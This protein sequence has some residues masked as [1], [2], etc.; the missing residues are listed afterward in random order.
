MLFVFQISYNGLSLL[1]FCNVP[2]QEDHIPDE[3]TV[4]QGRRSFQSSTGQGISERTVG[5]GSFRIQEK[6]N[7]EE[8]DEG[9]LN[10]FLSNCRIH[11][12]QKA[13]LIPC[14][15]LP[16]NFWANEFADV[17]LPSDIW[18]CVDSWD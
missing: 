5:Q 7:C 4:D 1:S 6:N 3:R 15:D 14:H 17:K 16:V 9:Q 13:D 2:L 10:K 18:E 12:L 11:L 8:T